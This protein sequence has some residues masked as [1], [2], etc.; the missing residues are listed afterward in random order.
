MRWCENLC[1]REANARK[2]M[3]FI[4]CDLVHTIYQKGGRVV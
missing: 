2:Y 3:G 1:K 4:I